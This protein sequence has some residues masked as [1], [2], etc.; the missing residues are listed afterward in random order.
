MGKGKKRERAYAAAGTPHDVKRFRAQLF[1]ALAKAGV[2]KKIIYDC[3]GETDYDASERTIRRHVREMER[4][5]DLHDSRRKSGRIAELSEEDWAVVAGWILTQTKKVTATAVQS[6]IQQYFGHLY[7]FGWISRRIHELKLSYKLAGKKKRKE[8]VFF[9]DE[10]NQYYNFVKGLHD[11]GFFTGDK[12]RIVCLDFTTNKVSDEREK[13]IRNVGGPQPKLQGKKPTYTNAYLVCLAYE[14]DHTFRPRMYTYDPSFKSFGKRWDEVKKWCDMWGLDLDQ[15]VYEAPKRKT[16]RYNAENASHVGDYKRLYTSAFKDAHILHDDGRA[17]KKKKNFMLADGAGMH[18][19]FPPDVHQ[20][21]SV[22][23]NE[24]LAIAKVWW[25]Q[26]RTNSDFAKD[27]LYLLFCIQVLLEENIKRQW[28]KNFFLGEN[29]LTL[30]GVEDY[31]AERHRMTDEAI[32]RERKYKEAYVGW[33][34]ERGG[35]GSAASE[36]RMEFVN[37][38]PYWK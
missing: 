6:F 7:D 10:V 38:G 26:G 14:H 21:L 31:L 9:S 35:L 4:G 5:G 27:A 20:Y 2:E 19:V 16:Q 3:I 37:K 1:A 17:W 25:K 29:K 24:L 32:L 13:T 15:I 33:L 18:R 8:N 12:R 22:L 28:E 23:D 11:D 34:E 36:R 30:Q